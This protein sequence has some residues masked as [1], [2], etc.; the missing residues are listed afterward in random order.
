[1][2]FQSA[3]KLLC[4]AAAM[5]GPLGAGYSLS[6]TVPEVAWFYVGAG[7]A[8]GFGGLCGFASIERDERRR[9]HIARF[10]RE[11]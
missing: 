10:G 3:F 2:L 5:L 8:L 6:V 4:S 9:H 1:M 7:I 11:L